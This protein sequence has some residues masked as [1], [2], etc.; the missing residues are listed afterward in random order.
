[1]I[2][3]RSEATSVELEFIVGKICQKLGRRYDYLLERTL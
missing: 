2:V 1:M 3:D